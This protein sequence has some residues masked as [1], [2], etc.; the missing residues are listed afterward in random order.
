MPRG[1]AELALD[2]DQ[3]HALA[4]HLDGVGV[5]ELVGREAS[6]HSCRGGDT[7][8]LGACRGGRP[9]APARRAIDDAEQRP[10]R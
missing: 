1:G 5:A 9:V 3:R 4:G 8:Q 7:P 10:D 6:T 2:D